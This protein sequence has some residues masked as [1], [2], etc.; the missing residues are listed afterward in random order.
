MTYH[1]NKNL[2]HDEANAKM[3]RE[4][5]NPIGTC[6]DATAQQLINWWLHGEHLKAKLVHGIMVSNYPGEEGEVIAHAWIEEGETAWEMIWGLK[7]KTKELRE[8]L[9]PSFTI[10]YS[11]TEVLTKWVLRGPPPW[12]DRIRAHT[13]EGKHVQR[14]Q[15]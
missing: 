15:G 11:R 7:F 10:E 4:P 14:F 1:P 13:T 3:G 2:R 12:D 5:L 8:K 6:F 9:N